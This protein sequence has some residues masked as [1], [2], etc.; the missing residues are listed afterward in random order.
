M[1]PIVNL[2]LAVTA[3]FLLPPV[4]RKFTHKVDSWLCGERHACLYYSVAS[5]LL[6]AQVE[7]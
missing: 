4:W 7:H 3:D 6:F 5:T 2:I 1:A